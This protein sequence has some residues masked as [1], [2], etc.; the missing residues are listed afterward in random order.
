MLVANAEQ[1]SPA[2]ES[3]KHERNERSNEGQRQVQ[4]H[5][6]QT[7][8]QG[9]GLPSLSTSTMYGGAKN[10]CLLRLGQLCGKGHAD[11]ATTQALTEPDASGTLCAA[12]RR[13]RCD[14]V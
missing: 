13:L 3:H 5:A 11:Q 7:Q 2:A 12:W 1:I 10:G 6:A 9:Q 14:E 8:S 4:A